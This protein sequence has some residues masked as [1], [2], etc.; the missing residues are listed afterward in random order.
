MVWD[1]VSRLQIRRHRLL[2][3]CSLGS[4]R[5]DVSGAARDAEDEGTVDKEWYRQH[6]A[7]ANSKCPLVE[8][9]RITQVDAVIE[10]QTYVAAR[11]RQCRCQEC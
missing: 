5:R 1:E 9:A 7:V 2:P 6:L 10:R 3:H 8:M 4:Q 11:G